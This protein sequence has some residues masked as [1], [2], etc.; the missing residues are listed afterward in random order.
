MPLSGNFTI[1]QKLKKGGSKEVPVV[2]MFCVLK[3]WEKACEDF[4]LVVQSKDILSPAGTTLAGRASS[5]SLIRSFEGDQGRAVLSSLRKVC[6]VTV[7][8]EVKTGKRKATDDG[9]GPSGKR[10]KVSLFDDF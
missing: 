1:S 6:G 4:D 3:A 9:D 2:S 7:T 5:R 8:E 10:V